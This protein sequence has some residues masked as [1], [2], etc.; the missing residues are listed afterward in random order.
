MGT[1]RCKVR[2]IGPLAFAKVRSSRDF[3]ADLSQVNAPQAIIP[4]GIVIAMIFSVDVSGRWT[5]LWPLE[6]VAAKFFLSQGI[7]M[8]ETVP[9]ISNRLLHE[10]A[11]MAMTRG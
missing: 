8:L 1:R 11:K 4:R 7:M 3:H 5:H 10:A 6:K 9:V 2:L